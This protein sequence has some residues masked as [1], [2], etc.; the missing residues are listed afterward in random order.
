[1]KSNRTLN[2]GV[3]YEYQAPYWE[4]SNH[5]VNLDVNGDFT[6]VTPVQAGETGPYTGAFPTTAVSPDRNNVSPRLG[7]AWR[8][9]QK[10]IV[11]AGYGINYASLPYLSF[12]QRLASQPP[13]AVTDTRTGT[14]GSPLPITDVFATPASEATTNNFGVDRDYRLGYVQIW[15]ADVQ[16]DV[17]RTISAGASYIGTRGSQLDLLRAP[18]RAADG[19]LVAGVQPF[20]SHTS[21]IRS[22][23]NPAGLP[24]STSTVSNGG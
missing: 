3:R 9:N 5:L 10:T 2:A 12:A 21:V 4:A 14:T 11:R 7:A 20:T 19:T 1:V 6:A 8:P 24:V 13:F 16:R 18:N 17:T 23:S 22:M 15:N